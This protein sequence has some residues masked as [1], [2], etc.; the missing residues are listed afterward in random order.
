MFKTIKNVIKKIWKSDTFSTKK[1]IRKIKYVMTMLNSGKL[2]VVKKLSDGTWRVNKW[3]KQAI[4]M[5]F[6]KRIINFYNKVNLVS[7][8]L[9]FNRFINKKEEYF[10][11]R[12]IRL[13]YLSY[14][15]YGSYIGKN[16]VMMPTFVNVGAYVSSGVLLD[17]WATIG[18]CAYIGKNV[19][20]S[21]GVGIGGVLE[22]INENPVIIEDNCFIGARSEIVE[23]VLIGEG[24][25]ISMGVYLG[26][27][28]KIYDR[29][30]G[31]F[32]I[33]YVPPFSVVVPGT[34][35]YG[36]Y[37][38][39]AAIIVKRVSETTSK[40]IKI[41]PILRINRVTRVKNL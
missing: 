7:N 1:S 6:K 3:V 20:I 31:K 41:N 26:K 40:K 27:S 36:S 14:V 5:F 2:T 39:Y 18:S 29:K 38:L 25:V 13:T 10:K 30:N 22:P 4:L 23:G 9:F 19:H 21:G 16:V 34:I 11:K 33:A 35:N 12:N 28:T 24:S 32:Y 8:D 15:R 37:S 17:T